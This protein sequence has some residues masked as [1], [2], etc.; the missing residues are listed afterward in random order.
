MGEHVREDSWAPTGDETCL[1]PIFNINFDGE[2][3]LASVP[4]QLATQDAIASFCT[5][6]G[7]QP[8]HV[9]QTAWGILLKSYTGSNYPLFT[10]L[11]DRA[12]TQKDKVDE[13]ASCCM[14][15]SGDQDT[16]DLVRT[17]AYW[18]DV[19]AE[20]RTARQSNTAVLWN[21]SSS[22]SEKV[23]GTLHG[24]DWTTGAKGVRQSLQQVLPQR[25]AMEN[26]M[27]LY[28]IGPQP[29]QRNKPS[30]LQTSWHTS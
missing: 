17:I 2:D 15:L 7:I 8:A 19:F 25:S 13:G 20:P 30:G 23:S 16:L 1:F 26:G 22:Y 4:V 18:N 10:C 21:C 3:V 11:D 5:K 14:D 24:N 9:L 29:Y 27:C 12:E 6:N 28:I